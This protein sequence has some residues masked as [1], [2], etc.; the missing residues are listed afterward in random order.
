MSRPHQALKTRYYS[1]RLATLSTPQR[2][3]S[4]G[5][6]CLPLHSHMPLRAVAGLHVAISRPD[7]RSSWLG[8]GRT[9][10]ARQ[11]VQPPTRQPAPAQMLP[12][13]S[14]R[15]DRPA[16]IKCPSAAAPPCFLSR[17]TPQPSSQSHPV[18][19][20]ICP[21]AADAVLVARRSHTG[22]LNHTVCQILTSQPLWSAF[23]V[24]LSRRQPQILH[25]KPP[26]P[27]IPTTF[28]RRRTSPLLRA[29]QLRHGQQQQQ[30]IHAIWLEPCSEVIHPFIAG[31][32][33]SS[34]R[35]LCSFAAFK[36]VFLFFQ[37]IESSTD[38]I[39][40]LLF[41]RAHIAMV[42]YPSPPKLWNRRHAADPP[43]FHLAGTS[44][45]RSCIQ[46]CHTWST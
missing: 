43:G 27:R 41:S 39:F 35:L 46:L 7:E 9:A 32:S 20:Y 12:V 3:M 6:R 21:V 10:W 18:A 40:S 44:F 19:I 23:L 36:P 38:F 14:R 31:L 33:G 29:W 13:R 16:A 4:S 30:R 2:Y 17:H 22:L 26:F 34:L 1:L 11:P 42:Q 45:C 24:A 8:G 37:K 28:V 15:A 5:E 25:R